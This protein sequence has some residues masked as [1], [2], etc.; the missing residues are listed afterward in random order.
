MS[1]DLKDIEIYYNIYDGSNKNS[2]VKN[3]TNYVDMY[4]MPEFKNSLFIYTANETNSGPGNENYGGGGTALVANRERAFGIITGCLYLPD[5]KN[6]GTNK[7]YDVNYQFNDKA[8]KYIKYK[9][10]N[11]KKNISNHILYQVIILSDFIKGWNNDKDNKDKITNIILPLTK[12]TGG[13]LILGVDL[14]RGYNEI[15]DIGDLWLE[16]VLTLFNKTKEDLKPTSDL[17]KRYSLAVTSSVVVSDATSQ[18]VSSVAI[19]DAEPI[20]KIKS[21]T[22]N[23]VYNFFLIAHI[24][25]VIKRKYAK[26]KTLQADTQKTNNM[27]L[28]AKKA[29]QD[30]QAADKVYKAAQILHNNLINAEKTIKNKNTDNLHYILNVEKSVKELE[31]AIDNTITLANKANIKKLLEYSFNTV[32]EVKKATA[33]IKAAKATITQEIANRTEDWNNVATADNAKEEAAKAEAEAA[34]AEAAEAAEAAKAKAAAKVEEAKAKAKAKAKAEEAEAEAAKASEAAAAEVAEE[35][36]AAETEA[37]VEAEAE[38]EATIVKPSNKNVDLNDNEDYNKYK[39]IYT[40]N[41]N[42]YLTNQHKQLKDYKNVDLKNYLNNLYNAIHA[43]NFINNYLLNK[44][45]TVDAINDI[46]Q[47]ENDFYQIYNK[48]NLLNKKINNILDYI[49]SQKLVINNDIKNT[50]SIIIDNYSN[51]INSDSYSNDY[52]K[53]ISEPKIDLIRTYSSNYINYINVHNIDLIRILSFTLILFNVLNNLK[54]KNIT[55]SN[56]KPQII[57]NIITQL[58]VNGYHICRYLLSLNKYSNIYNND[59]LYININDMNT[60]IKT[61]LTDILNNKISKQ[62]AAKIILKLSEKAK[63]SAEDAKKNKEKADAKAEAE[64]EAAEASEAARRQ[65]E[66]ARLKAEAEAIVK[67][68]LE[69]LLKNVT[70]NAEKLFNELITL[71]NTAGIKHY[72]ILELKNKYNNNTLL[73]LKQSITID[74]PFDRSKPKVKCEFKTLFDILIDEIKDNDICT[75]VNLTNL[76]NSVY[77]FNQLINNFHKY[78]DDKYINI[79]NGNIV[80]KDDNEILNYVNKKHPEYHNAN[81]KKIYT[82]LSNNINFSLNINM[83]NILKI[84]DLK[85]FFNTV[86]NTKYFT[87]LQADNDIYKLYNSVI[88]HKYNT[89]LSTIRHF[90]YLY[91]IVDL[92]NENDNIKSLIISNHTSQSESEPTRRPEESRRSESTRSAEPEDP[93][94]PEHEYVP[95]NRETIK[96]LKR[97]ISFVNI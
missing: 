16:S 85:P 13:E 63:K 58:K 3:P 67:K 64:A 94:R 57:N 40:E 29:K 96:K 82:E 22:F 31:N 73:T 28:I 55:I 25:N 21:I 47:K 68:M 79:E 72:N 1:T 75:S 92:I 15:D 36:A 33:I 69:N 54:Q 90:K 87:L 9:L 78:I 77:Y 27:M 49:I 30:A 5:C 11:N 7:K 59:M 46:K 23:V 10:V 53:Y 12:D 20:N 62:Q 97:R 41:Y 38:A 17:L 42:K 19:K 6:Y 51:N 61:H 8:K 60:Y 26:N 80:I 81:L 45:K 39:L 14:F 76:Q 2:K 52:I 89:K 91:S 43:Y 71:L 70:D 37:E 34:E 65:A 56:T 66:E 84:K 35:A 74:K 86:I 50:K 4:D 18:S 93:R 44:Y 48:K 95:L 24:E 32:L 83:F 88:K